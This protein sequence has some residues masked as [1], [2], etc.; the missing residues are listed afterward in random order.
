MEK[1]LK[2]LY[3][4]LL[5]IET[6]GHNTLQMAE[7]LRYT[8]RLVAEASVLDQKLVKTADPEMKQKVSAEPAVGKYAE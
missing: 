5:R 3:N 4:A 6:K 8:E 7:C 1:K 2:D